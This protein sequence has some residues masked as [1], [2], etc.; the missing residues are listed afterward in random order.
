VSTITYH[1]H[2]QRHSL[3]GPIVLIAIGVFFLLNQVNPLT[4]L[5]WGDMLRLWPLFLVFLGLNILVQQAP[6]PAGTLLSG[7][8]ALLAVGVFGYI[9]LVGLPGNTFRGVDVA[10]WERQDISYAYPGATSA[11]MDIEIGPP[12]AYLHALENSRD[13]IVGTVIARDGIVFDKQGGDGEVTVTLAP[14]NVGSWVWSPR[15]WEA[16]DETERW[17]LGLNPDVP[18]SLELTAAAGASDLDM[19]HLTL[20]DLSL[21]I[22]AG[23]VTA[24]LPG[25]E[26]DARIDTNAAA[27]SLMLAESGRQNIE[28][29]VNAGSVTIDLPPGMEARVEVDRA[30]GSFDAGNSALGQVGSS[31]VWQTSGY[32]D[33]G[34]RVLLQV[35]IAVG[36]VTI[37]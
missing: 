25:G 31:D 19:R 21:E 30:L 35:N 26:Y 8:V 15:Q 3:F 17:D 23:D 12:G 32:E 34:N 18:I 5:H 11:V 16:L 36:S 13:L 9:L 28:L 29:N 10:G 2:K 4:D 27:A 37:R 20:T 7:M 33:S 14:R 24:H 22:A 6:R 1:D